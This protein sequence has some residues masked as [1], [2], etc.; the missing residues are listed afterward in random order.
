MELPKSP[1]NTEGLES[2]INRDRSGVIM[3]LTFFVTTRKRWL[4]IT[5]CHLTVIKII[6]YKK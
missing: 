1:N 4:S 6:N 5:D 3:L 2:G